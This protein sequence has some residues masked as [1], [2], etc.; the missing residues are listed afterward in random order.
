MTPTIF[1]DGHSYVFSRRFP[2]DVCGRPIVKLLLRARDKRWVR[3]LVVADTGADATLMPESDATVLGI[4]DITYAPV[5]VRPMTGVGNASVTAFFHAVRATIRGSGAYFP[6][7]V[8][9]SPDIRT[10][11]FGR[12]DMLKQF[13]IAFDSRATYFMRD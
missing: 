2:F 4:P 8:G 12:P 11:L 3:F 1:I 13:V 5:D 6:I 7:L 10:R 9:F